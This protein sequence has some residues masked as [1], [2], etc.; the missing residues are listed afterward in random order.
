MYENKTRMITNK[1]INNVGYK[2]YLNHKLSVFI[3]DKVSA[4]IQNNRVHG[5][6]MRQT[7]QVYQSNSQ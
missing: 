5:H 2:A 6:K 4:Q 7:N 3:T 1:L